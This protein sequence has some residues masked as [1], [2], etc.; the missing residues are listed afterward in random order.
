MPSPL[1]TTQTYGPVNERTTSQFTATIVDE[2]GVAVTLDQITAATLTL[3]VPDGLLT[4]VN[5]RDAQDV[6]NTNDVTIHVD[7][8]LLTWTITPADTAILDST[9]AVEAHIFLFVITW[10]SGK[11]LKHEGVLLVRNLSKVP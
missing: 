11:S 9:L 10:G 5:S 3:Y 8:G 4:I 2:T 6:L 7:S 1:A